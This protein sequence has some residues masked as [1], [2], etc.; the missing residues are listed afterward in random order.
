MNN[1][2]LS[3]KICPLFVAIALLFQGGVWAQ[4]G[5]EDYRFRPES[6]YQAL[7][8]RTAYEQYLEEE[9]LPVYTGWMANVLKIDLK[10]WKRQ[11]QGITGAFVNLEGM[12]GAV[13]NYVME[14]QPGASTNPEHH[15]Y[16]ETT[17][18][19]S[20]E[21][22]THLWQQGDPEKKVVVHWRK[23]TIFA[24][25]L[26]TWHQH[27]NKGTT[28][29]RLAVGTTL[30]LIMDIFRSRNFIWNNPVDFPDRYAGQ[31]DYFDPENRIDF[32]PTTEHHSL[33]LSNMV[34]NA[35]TWRLF[36]AGQGYKDTDRHIVLSKSAMS[37]RVEQFPIGTYERGHR[38]KAGVTIVLITGSGYT[39]LW[40]NELGKTPWKEEKGDQVLRLE[41]EPG[42]L[43]VPPEE[44][45][46]QHFNSGTEPARYVRLGAPPGNEVYKVGAVGLALGANTRIQFREED[47]YVR[48]LFEKELAKK[49][50]TI[51]MPSQEELIRLEEEAGGGFL[52]VTETSDGE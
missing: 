25:P 4:R 47:P 51:Q 34:R 7:G 18:V 46:H 31:A 37:T 50:A 1:S 8:K 21:G 24:P 45:Y 3:P 38:H 42:V 15:I 36:N 5:D 26:N 12:G 17:F 10:P 43:F 16:E 40:P 13:D 33:T 28:P 41:W 19:M 2:V 27:F 48:N 30:P 52:M 23:G 49:G 22:E 11:G 9:N 20:G 14:I 6:E 39:F 29:V 44:W 35:W 32:G